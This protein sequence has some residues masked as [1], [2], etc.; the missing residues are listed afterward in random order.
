[1]KI[2]WTV[3]FKNKTFWILFIPALLMLVKSVA[4]V[5]GFTLELTMLE[6]NLVEV[7]EA[8]FMVLGIIGI[9]ADPTTAG[10]SDS[11]NALTYDTPKK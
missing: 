9:V 7:V 8:V 10:I 11:E 6:S 2:N 4:N 3:R 5:F 1:M